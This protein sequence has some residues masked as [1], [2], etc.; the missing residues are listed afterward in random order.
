[1]SRAL[2]SDAT[3]A[4]ETDG[5]HAAVASLKQ[6][7]WQNRVIVI[8]P[9]RDNA[10]AARQENQLMADRGGLDERDIIVLKIRGQAILPLFGTSSHLDPEVIARDLGNLPVG[11]FA[12]FL[13]GKDGT[14]KL[15]VD[16]PITT[17]ELFAIIDAMPMRAADTDKR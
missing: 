16:E 3:T 5:A 4:N 7:Q 12:V 13:V 1:M 11:E 10:R 17:G 8:F 6:F 2:L 15:N 9:D 14:V